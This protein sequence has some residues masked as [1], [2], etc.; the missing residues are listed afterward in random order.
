MDYQIWFVLGVFIGNGVGCVLA[1]F[2]LVRMT[3]QER[4]MRNRLLLMLVGSWALVE[5]ARDD[6]LF[7]A[8][9]AIH[10]NDYQ[11]HFFL[12]PSMLLTV[13]AVALMTAVFWLAATRS[14]PVW[15]VGGGTA[16]GLILGAM[17]LQAALAGRTESAMSIDIV[18]SLVITA[19]LAA[20]TGIAVWLGAGATRRSAM[21]TAIMLL[22]ICLTAAQYRIAAVAAIDPSILV[23]SDAG[24]DP[25]Q[26]N[27]FTAVAFGIRTI[28]LTIMS[29]I[30]ESRPE[31]L[32]QQEQ[33]GTH[34]SR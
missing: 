9:T 4:T 14:R 29:M 20:A 30:D 11:V 12:A 1:V 18:N 21:V 10:I 24:I 27:V 25:N 16:A 17:S 31:P 34:D 13:F 2:C 19:G 7:V 3:D 15:T 23:N 26:L 5:T 28:A 33:F 8:A 32:L 6:M 22:A